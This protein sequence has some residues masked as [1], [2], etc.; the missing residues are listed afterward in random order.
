MFGTEGNLDMI[1]KKVLKVKTKTK[2]KKKNPFTNVDDIK[3]FIMDN[4]V[5]F[6]RI[7]SGAHATV[8]K[9]KI[10]KKLVLNTKILYPGEYVLK[11]LIADYLY[12]KP[13]EIDYLNLLSKY[14]LIPKIFIIG[15]NYFIG[16]YIDGYTLAEI[17]Y[18]LADHEIEKDEYLKIED[19]V[20]EIISVWAKLNFSHKDLHDENILVSK[21][22][23]HIYLI[24][25]NP[26]NR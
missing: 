14:G 5:F 11:L 17:K 18:M 23:N 7:G 25:P 13:N 3:I 22:F 24:D 16:K 8:Y 26:Y 10:D 20:D 21:D 2:V 1:K 9:F 6:K 12:W 15:R 19:S 4:S